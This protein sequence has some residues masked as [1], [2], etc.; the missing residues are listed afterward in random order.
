MFIQ[1]TNDGRIAGLFGYP[2]QPVYQVA[3]KLYVDRTLTLFYH[4]AS[5]NI[6][7]DYWKSDKIVKIGDCSIHY[8]YWSPEKLESIGEDTFNFDS[9]SGKIAR[10]G[11]EYFV[12]DYDGK[13]TKIGDTLITYSYDRGI[14]NPIVSK[15]G[16]NRVY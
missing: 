5:D 1:I 12:Y 13:L 16:D 15:I 11:R 8:D 3:S 6:E 14:S 7:Y 2:S 9:L 10:I 4:I